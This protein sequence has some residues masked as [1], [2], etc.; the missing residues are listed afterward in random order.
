MGEIPFPGPQ[1]EDGLVRLRPWSE[2]EARLTL[3]TDPANTPSQRVAERCGFQ[4]EGQMRSHMV[5][6]QSGERRDALVYGLLPGE[7]R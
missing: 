5:I 6:R 4:R 1:L 7:L 2:S 3:L